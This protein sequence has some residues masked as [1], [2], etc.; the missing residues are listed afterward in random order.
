MAR[1]L[2]LGAGAMGT[3]FAY[4]CI[5]NKH[6]VSI[7]GTHLENDFID[8][9]KKK[10]FHSGLNLE[11][12]KNIKFFKHE[13]IKKKFQTKPDLVV[14]GVSSKGI[15]WVADELKKNS[16]NGI[17]PPLLMLTKGL[18]INENKYELLVDKLTRLL[19]QK[20]IKNINVSAVG[21]PCLAAGLANRVHS[22]VVIANKKL[23]SAEL[24]KKMLMTN[25]Y[26]ISTST[27]INGVE[28]CAAIKN[29][30]SMAIG[31]ASGLNKTKTKNNSHLNTS[32]ALVRQSIYE[33]EIFVEFLKGRKETVNGLAGL[34]D[35]YV[36]SAGGRN[37]KMGAL[38]GE[39]IVFSKA[40]RNKM[41]DIT[42]EGA[43][44]IFEIGN[45]VKKDFNDKK[46]P[47]MIAMINAILNDTKL[48]IKWENFN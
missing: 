46:L 1:I 3:A 21:G 12:L 44:L 25:Y 23:E 11:V 19:N 41:A 14:L 20:G 42:V 47:L 15:E 10:Y 30:F 32:A 8:G 9:L 39:G 22:G 27:D 17:L 37:S 33:M 31:A 35:L 13:L 5:D 40:K 43:E 4:P 16:Y 26:H 6:D 2:I 48:E 18:S 36:S 38:I 7:I 24:L 28:V 29:I 45:K 34:G